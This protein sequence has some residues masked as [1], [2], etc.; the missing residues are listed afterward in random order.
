MTPSDSDTD[1]ASTRPHGAVPPDSNAV[2]ELVRDYYRCFNERRLTDAAAFFAD[3][4]VIEQAPTGQTQRGPAAYLAF[5]NAWVGAFPDITVAVEGIRSPQQGRARDVALLATGTHHG[6]LEIA[7]RIFKPTGR[8]AAL[9]ARELLV[10]EN[11][12]LGFSSLSFDLHE[13]IAQ[14]VNI[15]VARLLTHLER[16]RHLEARLRAAQNDPMRIGEVNDQIGLELDAARN[17]ARPY[18]K[19]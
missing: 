10:I 2:D 18:F 7:G 11:G 6:A 1:G 14:L 17:V 15:D 19:R 12:K 3:D 13:L 9:H 16:L 4:A 5:A 8:R